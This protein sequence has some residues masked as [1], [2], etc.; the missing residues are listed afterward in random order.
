MSTDAHHVTAPHP[1]GEGMIQAM[2]RALDDAGLSPAAVGYVNAHGTGTA[3][4]D[5]VETRALHQAFGAHARRLGVSST[6]SMLGHTM[7]ASGAIECAVTALA[8]RDQ[9][10]PPT[11]NLRVPDPECDLDYVPGVARKA[12]FEAAVSSSFAFGGSNVALVL[13]RV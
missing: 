5:R 6:K 12:S 1:E 3:L 10:L 4:N 8:L 7:G 11:A 9:V 2:R 13:R